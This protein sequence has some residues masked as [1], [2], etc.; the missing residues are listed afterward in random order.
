[1]EDK[2]KYKPD[3][4]QQKLDFEM[5]KFELEKEK[6][7]HA[8]NIDDQK[9]KSDRTTK[10]WTQ[11]SIFTPLVIVIIGFF[12]NVF[13]EQYKRDEVR[14]FEQKQR[15]LILRKEDYK[16]KRQFIVKQLEEFYY[17]LQF[18]LVKNHALFEFQKSNENKPDNIKLR[19]KIERDYMPSNHDEIIKIIDTHYHLLKNDSDIDTELEPLIRYIKD[20]QR[21]VAT[22]KALIASKDPRK[23]IDV[24][25][26]FPKDFFEAVNTRVAYLEEKRDKLEDA[27]NRLVP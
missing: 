15:K 13:Y 19:E 14:R 3:I 18:R 22:Y 21:H 23:T 12:L 7:E 26:P 8:K 16:A 17:P 10:L 27:F 4:E 5:E 11:V 9:L 1:M 25:E 24:A 2:K 6:F 20:Y